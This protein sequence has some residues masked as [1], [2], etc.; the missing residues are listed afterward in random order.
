MRRPLHPPSRA[1]LVDDTE[2]RISGDWMV[3]QRGAGASA[4]VWQWDGSPPRKIANNAVAD[5]SPDVDGDLVVWQAFDGLDFGIVSF[6]LIGQDATTLTANG[7]DDVRPVVSAGNIVYQQ[8]SGASGDPADDTS[9]AISG[10]KVIFAR[11]NGTAAELYRYDP[12]D[13]TIGACFALADSK[14]GEMS[15]QR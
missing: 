4:D 1:D 2:S 13:L 14:L 9:P 12:R 11:G 3:W 6:D 8:H 5:E 10:E 7:A 15:E